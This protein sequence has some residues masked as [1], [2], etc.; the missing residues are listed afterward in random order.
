MHNNNNL[1]SDVSNIISNNHNINE[2][3]LS[4]AKGFII[5]ITQI[6]ALCGQ[7]IINGE[8]I[9]ETYLP[10]DSNDNGFVYSN[11]ISGLSTKEAFIHS[12]AS[13]E[14]LITTSLSVSDIGYL[15]KSS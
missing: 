3:I 11:F 4:G 8:T 12:K 6:A 1:I 5:N 9:D 15:E 2:R 10:K 14:G 7:Q 13:R